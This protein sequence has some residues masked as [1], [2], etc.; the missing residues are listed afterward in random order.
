MTKTVTIYNKVKWKDFPFFLPVR[1]NFWAQWKGLL[2]AGRA[3]LVPHSP[4]LRSVPMLAHFFA[5]SC[6]KLYQSVQFCIIC[7]T[8]LV[9]TTFSLLNLFPFT[10]SSDRELF[11]VCVLQKGNLGWRTVYKKDD[12]ARELSAYNKKDVCGSVCTHFAHI[13]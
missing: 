11:T 10:P 13:C 6:S 4:S 9:L 2:F 8:E 3:S 5:V 7:A 12:S 1:R